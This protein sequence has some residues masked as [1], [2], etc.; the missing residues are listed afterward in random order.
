V[1]GQGEGGTIFIEQTPGPV[2]CFRQHRK[3]G[4]GRAGEGGVV[5]WGVSSSGKKSKKEKF[6][7][8]GKEWMGWAGLFMLDGAGGGGTMLCLVG[9]KMENEEN[10]KR[11]RGD[12]KHGGTCATSLPFLISQTTK[13][14]KRKGKRQ[15]QERGGKSSSRG[16][17][18]IHCFKNRQN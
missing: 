16:G 18:P 5:V 8:R 9:E 12:I 13:R 11:N 2:F 4:G 17:G 14:R 1:W 10:L 15:Q 6:K 7:T 3:G